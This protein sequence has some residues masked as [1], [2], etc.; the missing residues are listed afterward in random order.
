MRQQSGG[1]ADPLSSRGARRR[2][3]RRLSLG[4][5]RKAALLEREGARTV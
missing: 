2:R 3:A 4:V 5:A 1:R